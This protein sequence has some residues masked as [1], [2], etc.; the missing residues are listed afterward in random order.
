MTD[1]Q[2]IMYESDDAAGI[3]TVTGWVSSS[4]RF[5]GED[6]HMAR[7]DGSTHRKCKCG[8]VYSKGWTACQKCRDQKRMEV[9]LNMPFE[10]YAGQPVVIFDNDIYFWNEDDIRD[11]C[12]NEGVE[13]AE[14]DLVICEP[15]YVRPFEYGDYYHDEC[16]EDHDFETI[17]PEITK[18]I[19][20]L[21]KFITEKAQILS[22]TAGKYRTSFQPSQ[23]APPQP[24]SGS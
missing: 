13:F 1:Q 8:G 19:E 2:T 22:W 15:N 20:E 21:N 6:E 23:E 11:Y 10:S 3:K 18:K 16:P 5:W 7:Y 17:A 12:D 4:G 9:Y 24:A 14:L